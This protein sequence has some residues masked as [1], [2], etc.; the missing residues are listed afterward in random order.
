MKILRNGEW[1]ELSYFELMEAHTEYEQESL[2]CDIKE[3]AEEM[4]TELDDAAIERAITI[5]Q[6]TIA[7][8]DYYWSQYW[9]DIEY[10]I[11]E[12]TK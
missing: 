11:K 1:F 5:A 4:E 10:A 2:A 9:Q 7:N 6:R 3:R 8:D 12:A